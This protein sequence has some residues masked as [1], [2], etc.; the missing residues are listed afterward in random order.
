LR[1][2]RAERDI[3]G[4]GNSKVLVA[5]GEEGGGDDVDV[6]A[7]ADAETDR[8][9]GDKGGGEF[10]PGSRRGSIK[11]WAGQPRQRPLSP[12]LSFLNCGLRPSGHCVI[13]TS[14]YRVGLNCE[15]ITDITDSLGLQNLIL[16]QY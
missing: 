14:P 6:D 9:T 5:L 7:D 12:P 3:K 10:M 11:L 8:G 2:A 1:C 16:E 13:I 15:E 4:N